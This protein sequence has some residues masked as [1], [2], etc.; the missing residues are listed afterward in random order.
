MIAGC[1]PRDICQGRFAKK[2]FPK[3]VVSQEGVSKGEG[4]PGQR[5]PK[6]GFPRVI[7]QKT[8][9]KRRFPKT[10]V[11]QILFSEKNFPKS[12]P[13]AA[14]SQDENHIYTILFIITT[15]I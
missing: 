1:F 7:F 3:T 13:K 4:F 8:F 10:T 12:F 11:S 15:P 9:P 2:M 5:I 6:I 14:V